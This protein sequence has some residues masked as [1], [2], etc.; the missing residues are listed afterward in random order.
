MLRTCHPAV[1]FRKHY[2]MKE[3]CHCFIGCQNGCI[4]YEQVQ[5]VV[6]FDSQKGEVEVNRTAVVGDVIANFLSWS[7]GHVRIALMLR[8]QKLSYEVS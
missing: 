3:L 6:C 8:R 4:N 2:I 7:Y 5:W 1:E